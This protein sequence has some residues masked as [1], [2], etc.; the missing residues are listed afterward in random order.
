MTQTLEQL[1]YNEYLDRTLGAPE[2]PLGGAVELDTVGSRYTGVTGFSDV[3]DPI[4]NT[5]GPGSAGKTAALQSDGTV[6]EGMTRTGF[7]GITPDQGIIKDDIVYIRPTDGTIQK[8]TV[9]TGFLG[10]AET[11]TANSKVLAVKTGPIIKNMGTHQNLRFPNGIVTSNTAVWPNTAVGAATRPGDWRSTTGSASAPPFRY[12]GKYHP[13]IGSGMVSSQGI[14]AIRACYQGYMTAFCD[15]YDCPMAPVDSIEYGNPVIMSGNPWM[16]EVNFLYIKIYMEASD[17]AG[18]NTTRRIYTFQRPFSGATPAHPYI[19]INGAGVTTQ[20][21]S[22]TL[23]IEPNAG[24]NRSRSTLE[25]YISVSTNVTTMR[26]KV[27]NEKTA[28]TGSVR[29]DIRFLYVFHD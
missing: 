15:A 17:D 4:L 24:T 7:T 2:D 19:E 10:F 27:E 20:G 13:P 18:G 29:G 8:A 26:W 6:D 16:T 5:S 14:K 28:G 25:E 9:N 12:A 11:S 21:T 3:I 23:T 22:S 1:G